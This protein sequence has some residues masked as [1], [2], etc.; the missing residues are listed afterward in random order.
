MQGRRRF[1]YVR[2]AAA[3]RRERDC[4]ARAVLV[5][6]GCRDGT[7]LGGGW[8]GPP[9]FRSGMMFSK[10]LWSAPELCSVDAASV[11]GSSLQLCGRPLPAGR[12]GERE[13]A[14]VW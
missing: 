13:R 3:G 8:V 1:R 7:A 4:R 2:E 12:T 9:P 14:K 11:G 10:P 6:G 5:T